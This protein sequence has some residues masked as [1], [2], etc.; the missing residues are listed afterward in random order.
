MNFKI[1]LCEKIIEIE[2]LYDEVYRYCKDYILDSIECDLKIKITLDDILF[3][4]KKTLNSYKDS[5][6]DSSFETTAVYRK[7]CDKLLGGDIFLMHG[8]AVSVDNEAYL[9]IAPSTTGKTTHTKLWLKNIKGS[10]VVNGDKPLI[11]VGEEILIYGTPW[12]GKEKMQTNTSVPLKAIVC[13]ERAEEN[14]LEEISF[15]DA[16]S[17][18]LSQTYLSGEKTNLLKT[19][20]LL[21]KIAKKVKFYRLGCNM[22][23]SA[24]I[25][26]YNGMNNLPV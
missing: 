15:I 22:Q 25:T 20:E 4:K 12:C 3:E 1:K 19:V 23:D 16:F 9:F 11:K 2:S 24:A 17:R 8:S 7:I 6:E 26:A 13:L 5:F 21:N 14:K 18:L 10:F